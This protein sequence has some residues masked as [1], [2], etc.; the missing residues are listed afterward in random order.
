MTTNSFITRRI[1]SSVRS[2]SDSGMPVNKSSGIGRLG[3]RPPLAN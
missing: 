1:A 3:R 2:G